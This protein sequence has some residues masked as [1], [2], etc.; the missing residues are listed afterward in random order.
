MKKT[1]SKRTITALPLHEQEPSSCM[2]GGCSFG[3]STQTIGPRSEAS[4][5]TPAAG[6]A[7]RNAAGRSPR[8]QT[9]PREEFR[10]T[11][12]RPIS[13]LKFADWSRGN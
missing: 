7:G 9:V 11:R 6:D 1:S 2:A 3:T 13:G 8:H 4:A 5:R 12:P 10:E